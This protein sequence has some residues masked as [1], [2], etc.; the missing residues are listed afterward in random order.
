MARLALFILI[1]FMGGQVRA[2][3]IRSPRAAVPA[4]E[5]VSAAPSIPAAQA[6]TS[7]GLVR[8]LN[9]HYKT[10][11]EKVKGLYDWL[12]TNV[13]YDV[14][15]LARKPLFYE[16]QAL[17]AQ[18]LSTRKALCQGYAEVF[19]EVCAKMGV[20]AYVVTG[21]VIPR[22]MSQSMTHAWC[23]AQLQGQWY[24]FD[25][26]WGAGVVEKGVFISRANTKYFMVSPAKMIQTHMPFDP[27]WQLQ[28]Q[29]LT[30]SEFISSRGALPKPKPAFKF[31]DTLAT[32]RSAPEKAQLTGAIRRMSAN[33]VIPAVV[34]DQLNH[35]KKNLSVIR[36]NETVDAYN[37]AVK[38]F[39]EGINALNQ[40]IR[41][42]NNRFLPARSDQELRQMASSCAGKFSETRRLLQQVNPAD[43]T[44]LFLSLQNMKVSLEKA[45]AMVQKQNQFLDRYLSTPVKKREALFYKQALAERQ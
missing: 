39:N 7:D 26:T 31:L 18:T 44:N 17:I 24:L 1:F 37:M 10:P 41:Y 4:G 19:Q 5:S 6:S 36:E 9:S 28:T 27:M 35:L 2:Q 33:P 13:A 29:P 15:A 8:F 23:A 30:Y 22:G 21:F 11:Q 12:A 34:L 3:V 25:P 38:T 45:A 32:Y 14:Q 43:N 20:P 42:R 40:F 16:K